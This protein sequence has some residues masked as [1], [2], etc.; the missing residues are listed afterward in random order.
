M[1]PF[2]L[3]N[4]SMASAALSE[5]AA[6]ASIGAS[7][8]RTQWEVSPLL[9]KAQR[10]LDAVSLSIRGGKVEI[11]DELSELSR[12]T[13][14]FFREGDELSDTLIY[15]IVSS[16]EADRVWVIFLDLLKKI[17]DRGL[18]TTAW[19]T[20]YRFDFD[21]ECRKLENRSFKERVLVPL[22]SNQPNEYIKLLVAS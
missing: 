1:K 9:D 20:R 11:P 6:K 5:A 10:N 3:Y 2:D 13:H 12:A 16:D 8:E 18:P 14:K 15:E 19:E 4:L 21:A 7:P 22:L 17:K